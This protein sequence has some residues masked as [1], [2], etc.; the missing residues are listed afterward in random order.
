MTTYITTEDVDDVLGVDW[1]IP[2][3]KASAV[4][5]ANIYLTSL[6]LQCVPDKPY[7]DDL[8]QAGA[9]LARSAADGTLYKQQTESGSLVSKSVDADGVKVSKTY[10]SGQNS[11]SSFLPVDVQMALALLQPWR[12]N[13]LA[14]RVYR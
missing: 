11:S 12:S 9:L 8:I 2:D 13:P 1:T 7:P 6:N 10:D 3:K 5:Q 4:L 14:F